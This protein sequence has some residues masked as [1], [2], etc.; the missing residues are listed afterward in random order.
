VLS[1]A[2]V[3]VCRESAAVAARCAIHQFTNSLITNSLITNS[4]TNPDSSCKRCTISNSAS[5]QLDCV[6]LDFHAQSRSGTLLA[7]SFRDDRIGSKR[8]AQEADN[9]TFNHPVDDGS[10]NCWRSESTGQ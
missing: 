2:T 1:R 10:R 5:S 9:E 8:S 6:L 7:F 4:S 3:P